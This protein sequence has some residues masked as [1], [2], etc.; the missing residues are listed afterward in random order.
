[1]E[2]G[3]AELARWT[4]FLAVGMPVV[5]AVQMASD[6]K[7]AVQPIF[8]DSVYWRAVLETFVTSV[9]PHGAAHF[10]Q[11]ERGI[12]GVGNPHDVINTLTYRIIKWNRRVFTKT[13]NHT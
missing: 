7:Q 9:H 11:R 2:T 13:A 3:A 10:I 6:G 12:Q 1:M 4:A 8:Q 5:G